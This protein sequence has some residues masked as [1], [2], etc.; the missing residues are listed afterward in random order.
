[1]K[2]VLAPDSYKGSC[3]S[4]EVCQAME[5]GIRRVVPEAEIIK[6]PMADGGEGSVEA[7]IA[8]TGGEI[9]KISVQ[10]PLGRLITAFYGI[11]GDG[12][13]GIIEMAAASGLP[14]LAESER[15]PLKTSTYGT[16]QL[17]KAALDEGV[18]RILLCIGGSATNDGGMG[19]ARALG[20]KFLDANGLELGE[21]GEQLNNLAALDVG[22][23]DP[24]LKKVEI[25]VACDVTNPL[26]GPRGAAAIYGPQ[27]GATPRMVATLDRGLTQLAKV[28]R[29]QLNREITDLPGAGAAGGL[30]GGLVAFLDGK[31]TSGVDLII[32]ATALKEKLKGATLVF[33]GEGRLDYQSSFGKTISG[34]GRTAQAA[35]IPVIAIAGSIGKGYE[36]I[37]QAG[38]SG[39]VSILNTVMTLEEAFAASAELIADTAARTLKILMT[40]EELKNQQANWE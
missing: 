10:D 7:V 16:G 27:K 4:F 22:G 3:S 11:S 1:M 19:M 31:L 23:L 37:Y 29:E 34:V 2:I 25:K 36:Q 33:T 32:E 12:S 6:V 24:R 9:R 40:G 21:G 8:A 13:L 17:I 39:V 15:N 35:G 26:T 28:V 14:L 5:A 30:G 38:I 20:V 18:G